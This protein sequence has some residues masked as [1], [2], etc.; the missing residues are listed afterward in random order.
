MLITF[1]GD[2][3]RKKYFRRKKILKVFSKIKN[4]KYFFVFCGYFF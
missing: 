2:F 1:F 4:A 3:L